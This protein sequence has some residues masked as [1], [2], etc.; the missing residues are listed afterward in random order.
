MPV[1]IMMIGV[2]AS[3]KTTIIEK[4]KPEIDPV[5]IISTDD[6]IQ[7]V[8]DNLSLTYDQVFKEIIPLAESHM[9]TKLI[10]NFA[11]SNNIIFDRTN[12]P[13]KGRVSMLRQ[14]PKFYKKIGFWLP[15]PEK[16]EWERRLNSRPGKTIPKNILES[17]AKDFVV[18]EKSEGFDFVTNNFDSLTEYLATET[19]NNLVA[20]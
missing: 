19:K 20:I 5:S 10:G 1:F 3:G 9:K 18:P 15:V 6:I 14:V 2:P 11:N 4:I 13:P 7:S 16:D 12:L 17:M 8:A